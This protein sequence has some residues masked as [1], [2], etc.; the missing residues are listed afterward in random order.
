MVKSQVSIV[1]KINKWT[2]LP[3]KILSQNITSP[4]LNE[5]HSGG[6][7]CGCNVRVYEGDILFVGV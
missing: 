4:I 2:Q 1:W 6:M 7:I 3:Q 5:S